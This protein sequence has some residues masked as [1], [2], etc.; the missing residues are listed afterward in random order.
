MDLH[1]N[2]LDLAFVNWLYLEVMVLDFRFF[3]HFQDTHSFLYVRTL[4]LLND[5]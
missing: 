1:V 2:W 3:T 5:P 4:Y